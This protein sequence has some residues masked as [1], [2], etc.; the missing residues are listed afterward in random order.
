MDA[1]MQCETKMRELSSLIDWF[2]ETQTTTLSA[3]WDLHL[4]VT[5]GGSL[6]SYESFEKALQ[7]SHLKIGYTQVLPSGSIPTFGSHC[8]MSPT[9]CR[10][11]QNHEQL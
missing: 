8:Y 9:K 7:K 4:L 2:H 1:V 11:L 3:L 10:N 5:I 6:R